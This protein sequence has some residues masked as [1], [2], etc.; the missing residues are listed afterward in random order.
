MINDNLA[1]DQEIV[2]TTPVV[3][4][5]PSVEIPALTEDKIKE[6]QNKAFGHILNQIDVKLAEA[7]FNKPAGVK[8][9]DYI[10]DVIKSKPA[11]VVKE[12]S[13]DQDSTT[14]IKALQEALR[15]KETELEQVKASTGII[16]R[17]FYLDN[18][19]SNL[20]IDAPT[21]LSDV[22]KGRYIERA[23][24]T[25]KRE[26]EATYDLKEVN[27]QF[28]VYEK[29]GSP[30]LDGTIE[31]DS[32]KLDTLL[33]RDFSEFF[34]KPVTPPKPVT[35]TGGDKPAPA[36]SDGVTIPSSIKSASELHQYLTRD[37]GLVIG[38]ADYMKY[39][40]SA[41]EQRPAWFK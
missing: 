38:Q 36:S 37:K 4:E 12:V 7:G 22:E 9:T 39:I 21:H 6:I 2:E 10:L 26:L 5:V 13:S 41:K 1:P 23:R 25:I 32:I 35:G 29:D 24:T 28:K 20:N 33:K 14:K 19:L 30:V 17:E 11:E 40:S 31:M 18:T 27:G 34:A 16:K 3:T 8:T 15:T